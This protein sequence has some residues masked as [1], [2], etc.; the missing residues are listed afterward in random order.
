MLAQTISMSSFLPETAMTRLTRHLLTRIQNS[1]DLSDCM[2]AAGKWH[3][4][5]KHLYELI[6]NGLKKRLKEDRRKRWD[7]HQAKAVSAAWADLSAASAKNSEPDK[8][9]EA[10]DKEQKK[11]AKEEHQTRTELLKD[12]NGKY[13]DTGM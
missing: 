7:E 10:Q 12:L 8:Q 4:G 13:E 5:A 1:S 3:V 2:S 9:K 6:P 11:K